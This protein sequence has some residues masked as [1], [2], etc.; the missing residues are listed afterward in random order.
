MILGRVCGNLVAS[1][2]WETLKGHKLL[3]VEPV[4][5][6]LGPLG[7][8]FIAV[9]TVGAGE[10]EVVLVI[11]SREA[12]LAFDEANTPTDMGI[13]GIIDEIKCGGD[14]VKIM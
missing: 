12:T 5:E 8:P 4:D 13:T 6:A 1:C 7:P 3:M 2:K 14:I 10:D 11:E 9:D